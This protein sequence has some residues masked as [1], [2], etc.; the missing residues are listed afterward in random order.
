M[1]IAYIAAGAAGSYCG[2]CMRDAALARGLIARGHE[3]L[4]LPLYT[5]LR[6]D[7]PVPGLKRVFYGGINTWLQ[8]RFGLFRKTPGFV[9]WLFD[10]PWLLNLVGRAAIETRPEE[11]GAMTV[12]VLRGAEGPQR[13]ELE[14]LIEFL[15]RGPRPDV[16]NLTNSLLGGIAPEIK[17]RLGSPLFCTLQGEES[18][19]ARLP[20]QYRREAIALMRGHAQH[21]DL[22]LSPGEAYADEMSGFLAVPRKRIRVVRPGIELGSFSAPGRRPRAPFRIGFLSRVS[23]AKG[24]DILV[25]AF[26]LLEWKRPGRSVL[27]VAGEVSGPNKRFMKGLRARIASVGLA[28]RFEC[29]GEVDLAGKAHFLKSLSAFCLPSRYAEQRAVACLEALAVGVPVVVPRLGLF[30]ELL[31]VTG[32]GVLVPVEDPPAVADALAAMMD[33]PTRWDARGHRAA[34]AV[35]LHFSADAMTTR[36]LAVYQEALGPSH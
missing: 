24:L 10:R 29:L 27:S 23:P 1:R 14:K 7:G 3:V 30:P 19:V 31:Q 4:F 18:F 20:Q 35:A 2:A 21:F 32:G 26:I 17:R 6:A 22:L 9:D 15:E 28:D 11:L 16:V 5:P 8:H 25:E 36:T 12:S 13:K 34:K 33:D